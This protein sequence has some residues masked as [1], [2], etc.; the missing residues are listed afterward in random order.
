MSYL[1]ASSWMR[2]PG[3]GGISRYWF[4]DNTGGITYMDS[5]LTDI[6]F[7]VTWID[8]KRDILYALNEVPDQPGCRFGGGGSIY[9]L[10]LDRADGKID[11]I[12]HYPAYCSNPCNLALDH[13][14]R[15]MIITGHGT[16]N[17]I[18]KLMMDEEGHYYPEVLTDDTPVILFELDSK[19]EPEHI[20][21][22]KKHVGSGPGKKQ[23]TAH[24]H[25]A[26]VSPCGKF[27][28]VCD[29]GLDSLYIYRINEQQASLECC[30]ICLEQPGTEPRYSVFHPHLPYLYHNTENSTEI[31]VYRYNKEG[32]MEWTGSYETLLNKHN[33]GRIIEQQGL[34]ISSD[35]R[36]LYDI[37]HGPDIIA[38]MEADPLDGSLKIIQNMS[39]DHEWPRGAAL[40]P[41]GRFL[42]A[43]CV[44]G[45]KLVVYAVREDGT[46]EFSGITA[47]L[48]NAS[49]IS[50]WEKTAKTADCR[51]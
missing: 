12:E 28:A 27:Y 7:N 34:C 29:K 30:D 39:I 9:A 3:R 42:V 26:A 4:D 51:Y 10:K 23:M 18:T 15:Y 44:R 35:G 5:V 14:S 50:F 21:D 47:D 1:F 13:D 20:L 25:C 43:A 41:D 31:F 11:S 22:I 37:I 16:K 33:N 6:S 38:V 36:Y 8:E 17:Y 46:L 24:P 19:G 49:Y 32:I 48:D 2:E 45:K 40:S